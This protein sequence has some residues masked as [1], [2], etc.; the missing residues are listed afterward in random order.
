MK[1]ERL[2]AV[3]LKYEK[4]KDN[5]PIVVA[6]GGGK[7][8]EKIIEIARQN[9]IPIKEDPDLIELLYKLD[10]YDEI[11]EELYKVVAEIF[12]YIYKISGKI[13]NELY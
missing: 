2:K 9:N 5:A 7:V 13:K 6:K 10:I 8:A 11:P 4:F 3:A 1:D 12:S